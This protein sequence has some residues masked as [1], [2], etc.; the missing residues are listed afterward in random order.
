MVAKGH[1]MGLMKGGSQGL[2]QGVSIKGLFGGTHDESVGLI[3]LTDEF[4]QPIH[5][6]RRSCQSIG[7]VVQSQFLKEDPQRTSKKKKE[8]GKPMTECLDMLCT[9]DG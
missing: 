2:E 1:S 5:R 9:A 7:D 3:G 6:A 4:D 8:K